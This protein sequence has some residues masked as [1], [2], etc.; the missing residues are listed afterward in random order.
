MRERGRRITHQ[1]QHSATRPSSSRASQA[2]PLSTNN[3]AQAELEHLQLQQVVNDA[4]F[5]ASV[6]AH[7]QAHSSSVS[8]SSSARLIDKCGNTPAS[9]CASSRTTLSHAVASAPTPDCVDD[10]F[11]CTG[12]SALGCDLV[13]GGFRLDAASAGTGED[14]PLCRS[15]LPAAAFGVEERFRIPTDVTPTR[16]GEC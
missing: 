2:A 15:L 6:F 5:P 7:L 9:D 14:S 11:S 3:S 12:F 16:C 13:A 10:T 4:E 1:A 8:P